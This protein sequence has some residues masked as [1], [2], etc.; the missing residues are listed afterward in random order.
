IWHDSSTAWADALHPRCGRISLCVVESRTQSH[1]VSPGRPCPGLFLFIA[2]A[3]PAPP[4]RQ[5]KP[6]PTCLGPG[7][8]RPCQDLAEDRQAAAMESAPTTGRG[9]CVPR[10]GGRG[11]SETWGVVGPSWS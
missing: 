10:A 5:K 4:S 8:S 7:G 1:L 6:R 9:E 2:A 3:P 11:S